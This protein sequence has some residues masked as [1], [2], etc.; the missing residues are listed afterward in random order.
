MMAASFDNISQL[1]TSMLTKESR[2]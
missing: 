1:A 2:Q